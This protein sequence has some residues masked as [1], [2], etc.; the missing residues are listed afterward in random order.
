MTRSKITHAGALALVVA[1]LAAGGT[2]GAAGGG[3]ASGGQGGG[4]S[5]GRRAAAGDIAT[6]L[7][8]WEKQLKA[9]IAKDPALKALAAKYRPVLLYSRAYYAGGGYWQSTY[10]FLYET[11]DETRHHNDV[12]L[13]FD[14]GGHDKTFEIN[15]TTNAR[16]IVADLGPV[17]FTKPVDLKKVD[18][19]LWNPKGEAIEGHVYIERVRDLRPDGTRGNNFYVLFKVITVDKRSR[20]MAFLWR[21]LPGGKVVR[22]EDPDLLQ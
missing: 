13:Q 12:Q 17:D 4:G 10:S 8:R 2:P 21:R 5:G 7:P 11:T 6:L 22:K 18:I 15:M 9:D 16:N 20:Y 14:N 19:D 1:V 3:Q